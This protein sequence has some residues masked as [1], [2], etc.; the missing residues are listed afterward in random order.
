MKCSKSCLGHADERTAE[1]TCVRCTGQRWILVRPA[2]APDPEYTC[3]RC[4]RVLTGDA[5]VR[6]PLASAESMA[7][8][9][10]S[11]TTRHRTAPGA[12]QE[13]DPES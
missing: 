4:R 6:D 12:T 1:I 7:R 3:T 13:P 5:H 2:S 11:A 9:P 8:R 10:A